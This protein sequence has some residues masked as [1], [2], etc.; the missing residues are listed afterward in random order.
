MPVRGADYKAPDLWKPGGSLLFV[1]PCWPARV[2]RPAADVGDE[3]ACGVVDRDHN[4]AVHD[5]A[6]GVVPQTERRNGL[7]GES[8]LGKIGVCGI[9]VSEGKL[10]WR[11]YDNTAVLVL[12]LQC[13]RIFYTDL[14]TLICKIQQTTCSGWSMP[15]ICPRV[16]LHQ[17]NAIA[18][19]AGGCYADNRHPL[20]STR[21]L[22]P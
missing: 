14:D 4:A 19:I 18:R 15:S 11:I 8:A 20:A 7:F 10:E 21:S 1:L 6:T 17:P 9:K 5:A 12:C 2:A 22:S 3:L 16:L 13:P